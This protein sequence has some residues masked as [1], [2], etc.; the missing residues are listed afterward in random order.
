MKK[1]KQLTQTAKDRASRR[2]CQAAA[3]WAKLWG[4]SALVTGHIHVIQWPEDRK[5]N[6]TI[7]IRCTG[8]APRRETA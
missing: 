5:F 6:Y 3:D 4:G 2:L 7:G 1:K 8:V